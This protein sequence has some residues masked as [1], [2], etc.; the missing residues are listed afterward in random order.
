MSIVQE[1]SSQRLDVETLLKEM[2]AP[3]LLSLASGRTSA[4]SALDVATK[5]ESSR[6]TLLSAIGAQYVAEDPTAERLTLERA[7]TDL[8]KELAIEVAAVVVSLLDGD[9]LTAK[10]PTIAE[11]FLDDRF[12]TDDTLNR[13]TAYLGIGTKQDHSD[14][15]KAM[16]NLF[17]LLL[18]IN[19]PERNIK[20]IVGMVSQIDAAALNEYPT[21]FKSVF[22]KSKTAINRKLALE[23]FD[24]SY[25][26]RGGEVPEVIRLEIDDNLQAAMQNL[27][28]ALKTLFTPFVSFLHGQSVVR[29]AID[30][31][32]G[33][34]ASFLDP[35]IAGKPFEKLGWQGSIMQKGIGLFL[36]KD[37]RDFHG[38]TTRTVAARLAPNDPFTA[39][40]LRALKSELM[41]QLA[42]Y[43]LIPRG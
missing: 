31:Q 35:L 14:I 37:R 16:P 15:T 23:E 4:R 27:I 43:G 42:Y 21:D 18:T 34:V 9:T 24:R 19:K 11:A 8:D 3:K 28:R 36:N 38:C 39:K 22:Y 30:H 17:K 2:R 29:G 7:E 33:D 40:S 20:S 13:I 25:P 26:D 10:Y 5:A 32:G 6:S 1:I 41:D 12:Y